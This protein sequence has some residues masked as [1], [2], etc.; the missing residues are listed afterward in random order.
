MKA[1]RSADSD[2]SGSPL[3]DVRPGRAKYAAPSAPAAQH[4]DERTGGAI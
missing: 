3:L 4:T 2:A 1:P